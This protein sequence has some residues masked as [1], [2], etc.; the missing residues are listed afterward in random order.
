MFS[1][2]DESCESLYLSDPS[3]IDEPVTHAV[4]VY[5]TSDERRNDCDDRR[6]DDDDRDSVGGHSTSSSSISRSKKRVTFPTEENL[7]IIREIPPRDFYSDSD[8]PSDTCE[9][10]ESSSDTESEDL[11]EDIAEKLNIC[12]EKIPPDTASKGKYDVGTSSGKTVTKVANITGV[13]LIDQLEPPKK[14]LKKRRIKSAPPSLE[15]RAQQDKSKPKVFKPRAKSAT[16][17]KSCVDKSKQSVKKTKSNKGF[18]EIKK[19]VSTK[20]KRGVSPKATS[21]TE[22]PTMTSVCGIIEVDTRVTRGDNSSDVPLLPSPRLRATNDTFWS[23]IDCKGPRNGKVNGMYSVDNGRPTDHNG[24]QRPDVRTMSATDR[25]LYSWLV[26]NGNVP[27]PQHDTPSISP[28]WE[29]N[30]TESHVVKAHV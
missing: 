19:C 20:V 22:D 24:H 9:S 23:V 14:P 21:I 16:T 8:T 7:V 18:K 25:R 1:S 15:T 11:D 30:Q 3:D 27:N 10:D 2:D 13:S 6:S 12:T 26:A 4:H 29:T 28:L 5:S 17:A